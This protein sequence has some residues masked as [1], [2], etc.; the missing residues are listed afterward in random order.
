VDAKEYRD[1]VIKNQKK[2][3]INERMPKGVFDRIID[4]MGMAS[5]CLDL[6]TGV[7]DSVRAS[8]IIMGLAKFIADEYDNKYKKKDT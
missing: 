5:T 4:D 1:E 3:P 6:N 7:Y 8:R 2:L